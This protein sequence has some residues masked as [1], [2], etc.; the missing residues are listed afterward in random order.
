MLGNYLAAH[1]EHARKKMDAGMIISV[2]WD[3]FKATESIEQFGLN[4]LLN[5]H[6]ATSL[7]KTLD[8]YDSFKEYL[9]RYVNFAFV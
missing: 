3:V 9:I 7:V 1:G 6:L 4:R 8:R 5:Y 2:P